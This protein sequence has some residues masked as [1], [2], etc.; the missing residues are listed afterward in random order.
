[1]I[2]AA[3]REREHAATRASLG[4]AEP[5]P[6]DGPG[7]ALNAA[8]SPRDSRRAGETASRTTNVAS[9]CSPATLASSS[10]DV[11]HTCDPRP[12]DSSALPP[13][14]SAVSSPSRTASPPRARSM[15]EGI[16]HTL[17]MSSR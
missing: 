3:C 16:A 5:N 1:M 10:S 12:S 11:Q 14:P 8:K 2:W 7:K 9:T 4:A 17:R 13:L 15:F 6:E